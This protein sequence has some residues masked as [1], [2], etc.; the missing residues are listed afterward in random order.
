MGFFQDPFFI[1]A[2]M[3]FAI[4]YGKTAM[5]VVG[6]VFLVFALVKLLG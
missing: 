5:I 6:A 2:A 1:A 4:A 3:L